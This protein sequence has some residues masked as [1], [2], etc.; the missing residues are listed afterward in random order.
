[1]KESI[2]NN[3]NFLSSLVCPISRTPLKLTEDEKE[4]IS[5]AAAVAFPIRNGVPILILD[6][7]RKLD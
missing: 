5:E 7:A 6:E 3:R 2:K 4:L 1:M